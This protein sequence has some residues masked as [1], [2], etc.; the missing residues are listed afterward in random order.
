MKGINLVRVVA[1]ILYYLAFVTAMQEI[2]RWVE[3]T[4]FDT[5]DGRA[6]FV[7]IGGG[8]ALTFFFASEIHESGN[9]NQGLRSDFLDFLFGKGDNAR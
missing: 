1:T 8:L 9:Y 3:P 5:K 4:F 2:F 7:L 6:L